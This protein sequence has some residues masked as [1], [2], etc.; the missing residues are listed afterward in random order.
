MARQLHVHEPAPSFDPMIMAVYT[1]S[2]T[3]HTS[4]SSTDCLSP[5]CGEINIPQVTPTP[6]TGGE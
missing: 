2:H 5:N 3:A 6:T 1:L 4:C